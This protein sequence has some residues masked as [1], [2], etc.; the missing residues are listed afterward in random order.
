MTTTEVRALTYAQAV[1]ETF[2]QEFERDPN[3]ILMGEDVAGGAGRDDFEDAWGGVFKLTRG[4]IGKF[5]PERVRDTPISE[6]G[7]IGAAVGSA[8]AG[9][10]P[11]A[12]LMFVGFVGVCGDQIF[13]NMAKMHYMFGGKV[14]LPLTV[15][16]STGAGVGSAAQHSETLYSIFVHFPGLKCVAPSNPYN[17]KGLHAAA[18]RDDDPVIVFNHKLLMGGVGTGPHVP[19][20]SY[21][22]EIGKAHIA[23]EGTDVTLI[24]ISYTTHLCLQAAEMLAQQGYSAE[25][26]DLLSLSPLDEETILESVKKTR[27]IVITDEDY[28]RCSVA[29][30]I[31]ALAVEQAFDYLDAPPRR[32]SAPHASV[33]YSPALEKFHP[34]RAE[35]VVAAALAVLE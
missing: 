7:F 30:D 10:R 2:H 25:V 32:V 28:P 5:G 33:P 9:L 35:D 31:S 11:I 23:R 8:A 27:K 16:T 22:V 17:A 15:I 14:K 3:V 12:D 18:I 6:N 26:V 4:L 19:Q 29:S 13:N 34:P 1:N 20:E 21:E 24:G